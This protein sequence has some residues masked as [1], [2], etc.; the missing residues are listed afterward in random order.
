MCLR[1]LHIYILTFRFLTDEYRAMKC[2]VYFEFEGGLP[3]TK[4]ELCYRYV[5]YSLRGGSYESL[6]WTKT[7]NASMRCLFLKPAVK[8]N[9]RCAT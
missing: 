6:D 4:R 8:G 7:K 9:S 5:V 2:T 1:F 3:E